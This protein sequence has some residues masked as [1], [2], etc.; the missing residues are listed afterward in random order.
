[1]KKSGNDLIDIDVYGTQEQVKEYSIFHTL[2][3][4][5]RD[6]DFNNTFFALNLYRTIPEKILNHPYKKIVIS[7]HTEHIH[8]QDLYDIFYENNDKQFLLITDFFSFDIKDDEAESNFWPD[9]VTQ[10]PWISWGEQLSEAE[11]ISGV[12]AKPRIPNKKISSLANRHE[13]HK[14]AI[15]AFILNNFL[16]EDII[17]SWHKG[18]DGK[19]IYYLESDYS[20]DENI[21]KYLTSEKFLQADS[22]KFDNFDSSLNTPKINIHWNDNNAYL[23]CAV[24]ITNESTFSSLGQLN[25]QRSVIIPGPFITEK[26]LKPLLSGTAFLH[27]GQPF[28]L[29]KLNE[30]GISTDFGFPDDY[31]NEP[32]EDERILKIYDSINFIMNTPLEK[33]YQNSYDAIV[34]NLDCIKSG[35]FYENCETHN[36]KNI[37]KIY[38]WTLI[39][40]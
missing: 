2:Y 13:Y 25:G 12:A 23:N 6:I 33:L 21:K 7:Y 35:T 11:K 30:L 39:N 40:P 18:D 37:K 32:F 4:N 22:I 3:K 19:K 16:I 20:I 5:F 15:T 26:T 9:N 34:N 24:N 31:D 36:K 1:M 10:I 27:V 28:L 38:D 17:I 8:Y 14:A 29:T